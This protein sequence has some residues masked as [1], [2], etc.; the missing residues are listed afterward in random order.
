MALGLMKG[1][2][3]FNRPRVTTMI[4]TIVFM[5]RLRLVMTADNSF[6]CAGEMFPCD[7]AGSATEATTT[8]AIIM[9]SFFIFFPY[10]NVASA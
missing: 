4:Q 10:S 3:T 1:G 6:R 8:D 5:S 2:M 9:N 7:A